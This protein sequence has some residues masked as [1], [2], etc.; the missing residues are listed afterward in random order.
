MDPLITAALIS[1]GSQLVGGLISGGGSGLSAARQ[2]ALQR[3]MFDDEKRWKK[4]GFVEN[5]RQFNVSNA[6]NQRSVNMN[7]LES[8][9]NMRTS[10]MASSRRK[11]FNDMLMKGVA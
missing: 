3:E 8:L 5:Q 1:G 11:I 6:M 7:A 9:A 2:L 4:K 10:A